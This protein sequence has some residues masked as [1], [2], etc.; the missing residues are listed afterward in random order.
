ML[1][2]A[3]R[4]SNRLSFQLPKPVSVVLTLPR[5]EVSFLREEHVCAFV[6]YMLF[7]KHTSKEDVRTSVDAL[8]VSL[9]LLSGNCPWASVRLASALLCC[10][11]CDS[12][13]LLRFHWSTSLHP[14]LFSSVIA[15]Y[16]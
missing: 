1:N 11:T 12:S 7:C 14:S 16:V 15:M 4:R 3:T 9:P 6:H 5:F 13:C 2:E 10:C 8:S